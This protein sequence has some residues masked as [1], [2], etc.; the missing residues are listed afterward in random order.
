M[1]IPKMKLRELKE[2]VTA[3]FSPRFTTRFPKKP[4]IVPER[5]RG[6]PEFNHDKC[7]GCG[8]CVNACPTE[9]LIQVDDVEAD[10]P[11]RNTASKSVKLFIEIGI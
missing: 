6:R 2:A 10:V 3:V 7:I 8:A 4:C 5:Y 9:S 11:V 1:R